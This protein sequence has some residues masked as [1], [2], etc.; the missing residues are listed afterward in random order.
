M[1]SPCRENN[2]G[3]YRLRID[4]MFR[5]GMCLIGISIIGLSA[6]T[7]INGQ[8]FTSVV[9]TV[10]P[11]IVKLYGAG[12][13]RGLE[14][15]QSGCLISDDGHILT[16]WSY[17]LDS[18]V[19]VAI[20]DDG[21]RFEARLTG[22]DPRLEMAIL[23]IDADGLPFF[24]LDQA[25]EATSG[26]RI[27]AFSNLYGVATGNEQASVQQGVVAALTSLATRR[28]AFKSAYQ[29]PIYIVDAMTNNPGS[30]GGAV[31]DD[32]GNLI[33]MIGKEL[34]NSQTNAWLNFAIPVSEL[35][36]SIDDIISGRTVVMEDL[37][38][39]NRPNEPLSL[40]LLGIVLVPDVVAKTPPFID[41]IVPGTA[42]ERAG[43]QEDDLIIEINGTMTTS[44]RNVR[45]L[46]SL[47]DRDDDAEL[48]VQRGRDFVTL[49][50]NANQ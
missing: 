21:Q 1:N 45:D 22:Y 47:I 8:G 50:L 36:S 4:A 41:R 18:D 10:Q 29:G 6:A 39:R 32:Q 34:R 5:S 26:S 14:A 16:V 15:Y 48:T 46:L 23:K 24:N 33:G 49:L 25:A 40:E 9:K 20:L 19:V 38:D 42:A 17:V 37:D 13:L 27:L 30:A 11:K 35:V 12:G 2:F 31:T 3:G 44:S 7:T 28:G 43:L